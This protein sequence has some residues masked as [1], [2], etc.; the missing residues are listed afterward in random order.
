MTE[1][2]IMIEAQDGVNWPIWKSLVEEVEALGFAGMFRSD[3]YTNPH[4][5]EKDSLEMVVS[6][7]Y[8]AE[9]TS[10]IHFGPLVA[11]VSFREPTMLARQAAAIDDLSEGRMLL[12][13]GAG[14]QDREHDMFGHN[15]GSIKE[16]M[17]RFEEGV[18]V[19]N[20]LLTSNEPVNFDGR[21][22]RLREA[23]LLP[24]PQRPGGP[25]ILIGGSGRNRTL[26]L[27]ARY[28]GQWNAVNP[29][30]Q[31]FREMSAR[32]DELLRQ[33]GRQ[34]GDVKRS[35]MTMVIF[36]RTR[37][38]LQKRL[39]KPPFNSPTLADKS[40]DEKIAT[41]RDERHVLVGNGEE[42][43]TQISALSEAGVQEIMTQWFQL[44]DLEGLRQYAEDVLPR[45]G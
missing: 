9:H 32:L 12:G 43:A 6:L 13:L 44:D 7:A 27:V 10:R 20:S 23:I 34:P 24:R 11:P 42:I 37:E 26:P 21:Y 2:S 36:G 33:E 5:P 41:W 1:L 28:A 15:L 18:E 17:D 25:P 8:L 19:V 39:D 16:R 3:H 30:V 38:D 14:W 29:T 35:I 22:F 31:E 40:L 4:D 45:L